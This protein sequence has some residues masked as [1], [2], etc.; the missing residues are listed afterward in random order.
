M[1]KAATSILYTARSVRRQPEVAATGQTRP[2][3]FTAIITFLALAICGSLFYIGTRVK[4]VDLGYRINQQIQ[5]K[6]N[7]IEE[8]KKLNLEIARLK[9]PTRIESE[10]RQTLGMTLATPNQIIYAD[11]VS[12]E[13]LSKT[14]ALI[15]P[16]K[17]KPATAEAVAEKESKPALSDKKLAQTDNALKNAK[18]TQEPIASKKSTLV[19]AIA[20]P[21]LKRDLPENKVA[22]TE[23][24]AKSSSKNSEELTAKKSLALPPA[25]TVAKSDLPEKFEKKALPSEAIEKNSKK[26]TEIF[27]TKK[28]SDV[29]PMKVA[30]S[31]L[32][33]KKVDEEKDTAEPKATPAKKPEKNSDPV[34]A[35]KN[36]TPSKSNIVKTPTARNSDLAP[37]TKLASN[38]SSGYKTKQ[39][40]PAI[41]LDTMP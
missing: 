9:S 25:K 6:E 27:A 7:L 16:G 17:V 39:N 18:K 12:T 4:V 26:S 11:R 21:A 2:F 19:A 41:M 23:A 15:N 24:P 10:A 36:K 32:P 35:E 14:L 34:I 8:S 1:A 33:V 5:I 29:A 37:G 30:K 28:S 40:V 38:K 20:K 31:D 22:Q 13:Q 3:F